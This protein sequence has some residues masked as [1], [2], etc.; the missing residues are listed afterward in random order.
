MDGRPDGVNGDPALAAPLLRRTP[1]RPG[2]PPG[3]LA[4]LLPEDKG[5]EQ[6]VGPRLLLV[7][8]EAAAA[9]NPSLV[10]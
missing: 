2:V 8:G 7:L 9:G 5:G 6:R 10:R 3:R 1:K 4:R